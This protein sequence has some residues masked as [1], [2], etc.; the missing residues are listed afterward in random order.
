MNSLVYPLNVYLIEPV[1]IS[2][3]RIFNVADMRYPGDV[4]PDINIGTFGK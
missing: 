2:L 4:D 3:I 1:Q